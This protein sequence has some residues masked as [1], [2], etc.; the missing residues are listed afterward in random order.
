MEQIFKKE[1]REEIEEK[2]VEHLPPD[3]RFEDMFTI[4]INEKIH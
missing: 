3:K 2:I 4:D 1:R